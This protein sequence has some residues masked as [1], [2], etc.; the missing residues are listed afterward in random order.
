MARQSDEMN[1]RI[2]VELKVV[3]LNMVESG[4]NSEMEKV[5]FLDFCDF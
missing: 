4:S 1:S 5:D 3:W 2:G